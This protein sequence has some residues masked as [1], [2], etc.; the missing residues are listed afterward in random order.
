[1]T[2]EQLRERLEMEARHES[3]TAVADRYGFSLSYIG[4][5]LDKRKAISRRLAEA[6][7][8]RRVVRFERVE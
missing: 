5:V 3:R 1:M 7:G 2:P 8:Y 6:M 4:A